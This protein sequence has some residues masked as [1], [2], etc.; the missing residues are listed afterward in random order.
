LRNKEKSL[1]LA[2]L[3]PLNENPISFPFEKTALSDYEKSRLDALAKVL[4]E[5]S[6]HTLVIIGHTD[7][8]GSRHYYLKLSA[9][10]ALAAKTYLVSKGV[11][12]TNLKI[13]GK[14]EEKPINDCLPCNQEDH[15]KNR[16]LQFRLQ[17]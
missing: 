14:G 13:Q 5:Q 3:K 11:N 10:M 15:Q 17:E 16:R 2:V 9:Q 12:P 6:D 4:K 1:L 8:R 7:K